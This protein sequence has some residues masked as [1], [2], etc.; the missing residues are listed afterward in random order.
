MP[1]F[2]PVQLATLVDHVPPGKAWLHEM[3]H[4]GYRCL[5]A[6][7]NGAACAYTRSGLDWS[8]KFSTVVDAA[9]KLDGTALIDGEIVV[10]DAQG[11]SN[12][13]ALQS[14]IKEHPAR[15][16]FYAFDLL[17]LNGQELKP[18]PQIE[19]KAR[20]AELLRAAKSG[21]IRL[22]EH[23]RGDGEKLLKAFCD[24]GLEG[25]VSK[26]ADAPYEGSRSGAWLKIK[27]IRREEFIVVGWIPSDKDR[28]FRALLLA[29]H[30]QGKLRYVG[31]VGT[32]FDVEE[33]SRLRGV[34]KPLEQARPT[35]EAPRA[36]VK[37]ARW[38]S[39]TLVAE[40][41][42]T[43]MTSDGLLRHPSYLG[44]RE[45]K[46]PEAVVLEK[47]KPVARVAG[48][49]ATSIVI[50]NPD[51][52]VFPESGETK[53]Q[54]AAYYQRL[55]PFMLPWVANR[56]ISL[57]RCPQGRGKKCFFQKHDGGAF[58]EQ[59][60][61]VAIAEKDGHEEAYIFVDNAE[62][63]LTCVQMGT[64]EFH[65]WGSRIEDV[66]LAD[67]LVFDLDPDEA[68]HFDQVKVAAF[69]IRD[70]LKGFDLQTFAMVTGGKGVH[71][72]APLTPRAEWPEVKDFASRFAQTLA[73]G[74]PSRF[75][76]ALAKA[77]R[78][79][80]IFVDYLRN[81]RGA[82]AVMPYG[83]R[84]RAGAPVAA[85]VTWEELSDLDSPARWRISDADELIKRAKSTALSNWGRANQALPGG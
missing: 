24:R 42:Y 58:G 1:A 45:D 48:A 40:V 10:L 27:C 62:G 35:V 76:A 81:Q 52:V 64:I 15:L 20:L 17:E 18:L 85:P 67:R 29:T 51:R 31:K 82:T 61:Q 43:E 38:L 78:G 4:D 57:V 25:V 33:M 83:V 47:V 71:V 66:E 32:G 16:L 30:E 60:K 14:A 36:A 2:Q 49:N 11:R 21:P 28:D 70:L 79:G 8:E 53:G 59:V 7:G 72:I 69:M 74:E 39:P 56:P 77:Q 84:S 44:L 34:M 12:F 54:L 9:A 37:E 50:T 55:A 63:L 3:K 41:A 19:R 22:S 26:R 73:K 13:Q 6:V 80:K 68:V 23:V 65:G 75:T 5:L 46:K